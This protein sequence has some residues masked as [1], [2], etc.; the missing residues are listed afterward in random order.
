MSSKRKDCMLLVFPLKD[1][2]YSL[3]QIIENS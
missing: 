1:D 3:F 2:D